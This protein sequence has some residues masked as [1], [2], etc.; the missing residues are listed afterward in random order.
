MNIDGQMKMKESSENGLFMKLREKQRESEIAIACYVRGVR[1]EVGETS[2]RKD[3]RPRSKRSGL[4][5]VCMA[6]AQ[7]LAIS[8]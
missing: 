4:C 8:L 2:W 5:L 1:E 7:H 3:E 6:Y